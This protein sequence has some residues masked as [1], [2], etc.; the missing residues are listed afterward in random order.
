M[1][2]IR[3]NDDNIVIERTIIDREINIA[4]TGVYKDKTFTYSSGI[5]QEI[6]VT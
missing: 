5:L 6:E 2:I 4:G 3:T 1:E